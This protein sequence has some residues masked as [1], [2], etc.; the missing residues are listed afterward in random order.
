ME[1]QRISKG[2]KDLGPH[3]SSVLCNGDFIKTQSYASNDYEPIAK[4]TLPRGKYVLTLSALIKGTSSG[5]YLY[6]DHGK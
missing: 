5:L 3:V 4:I 6:Q 2:L 1:I